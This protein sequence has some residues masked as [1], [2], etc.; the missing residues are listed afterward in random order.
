MR[1]WKKKTLSPS[2]LKLKNEISDIVRSIY[3]ISSKIDALNN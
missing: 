3:G 2:Q 1:D